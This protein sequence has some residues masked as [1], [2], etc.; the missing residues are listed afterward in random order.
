M[1]LQFVRSLLQFITIADT[2]VE[3]ARK[4][5][6]GEYATRNGDPL[7]GYAVA[8]FDQGDVTDLKESVSCTKALQI[9]GH[10]NTKI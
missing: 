9:R 5:A 4:V 1:T 3:I 6:P 8:A 7:A 2:P 10:A